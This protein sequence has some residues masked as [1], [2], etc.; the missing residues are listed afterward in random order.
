MKNPVENAM[1]IF[2]DSFSNGKQLM[3]L[4]VKDM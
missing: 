1:L 2:T 3:L 4:M